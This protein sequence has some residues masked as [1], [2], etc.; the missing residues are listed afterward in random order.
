MCDECVS[1]PPGASIKESPT[2]STQIPVLSGTAAPVF[3]PTTVTIDSAPPQLTR[4]TSSTHQPTVPQTL[5]FNFSSINQSSTS[6]ASTAAYDSNRS[7]GKYVLPSTPVHEGKEV[8]EDTEDSHTMVHAQGQRTQPRRT[9]RQ[10]AQVSSRYPRAHER[11]GPPESH[12][13]VSRQ[14]QKVTECRITVND[15]K[16]VFFCAPLCAELRGL[17]PAF[18]YF[19]FDD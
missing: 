7:G 3:L 17:C 15:E 14:K 16:F 9:P 13:H 18:L 2:Q 4:E 19:S 12:T 5:T 6:S 8:K 10:Q 1:T 11:K